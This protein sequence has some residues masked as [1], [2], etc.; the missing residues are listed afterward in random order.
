MKRK[1]YS[2]SSPSPPPTGSGTKGVT[3]ESGYASSPKSS[4]SIPGAPE[5]RS[6]SLPTENPTS[7]AT[8]ST[9]APIGRRDQSAIAMMAS[10]GPIGS[11]S[12]THVIPF[13]LTQ[14]ARATETPFESPSPAPNENGDPD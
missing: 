12:A 1:S 11:Y 14:L 8:F 5:S 10:L 4:P 6:P 3:V 9:T 2:P 7:P 13:S